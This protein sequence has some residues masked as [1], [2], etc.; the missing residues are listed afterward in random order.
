[1][2]AWESPID[3]KPAGAEPAVYGRVTDYFLPA[4]AFHSFR[5]ARRRA[6]SRYSATAGLTGSGLRFFSP[7]SLIN[8]LDVVSPVTSARNPQCS[9]FSSAGC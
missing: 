8:S 2:L 5:N 9:D 4:V 7:I 3:V 1:M 6:G